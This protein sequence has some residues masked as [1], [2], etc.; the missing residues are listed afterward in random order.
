ML[1]K[2]RTRALA[3]EEG[4]PLT[5]RGRQHRREPMAVESRSVQNPARP[6]RACNAASPLPAA[7]VIN[8][9]GLEALC[10]VVN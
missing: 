3:R 9:V 4:T 6:P 8:K 7:S 10:R 5:S 2:L 1:I